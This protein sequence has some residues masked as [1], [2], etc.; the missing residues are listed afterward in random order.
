MPKYRKRVLPPLKPLECTIQ[1]YGANRKGQFAVTLTFHS[2]FEVSE[3]QQTALVE[4]HVLLG[5][6]GWGG[7]GTGFGPFW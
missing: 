3:T 4:H 7:F 6:I 2:L 1:A 5:S